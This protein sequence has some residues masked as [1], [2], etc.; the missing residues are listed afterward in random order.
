ML[1]RYRRVL[2][3]ILHV[4]V[5]LFTSPTVWPAGAPGVTEVQ[6]REYIECFNRRDYDCFGKYYADDVVLSLGPNWPAL[7]GRQAIFDFYRDVDAHGLKEHMQIHGIAINGDTIRADLEATFDAT[8]DWPDFRSRVVRAGD[9][10]QL[11]GT[12]HAL[13]EVRGVKAIK[14]LNLYVNNKQGV[15]LAEMRNNWS[16]WKRVK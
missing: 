14:L 16:H 4:V 9:R 10:W 6:F 7:Q 15:D 11:R 12:L 1:A 13:Q 8:R 5:A 3:V 2:P